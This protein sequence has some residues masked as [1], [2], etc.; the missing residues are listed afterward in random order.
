MTADPAS[1]DRARYWD[2]RYEQLGDERVS[3]HQARPDVSLELIDALGVGRSAGVIDVGG[4]SSRLVDELIARDFTDLTVMDVSPVALDIARRRLDHPASVNW[5]PTDILTWTPRRRW[6]L[7]HDR[8]VFHFLTA[9]ADRTAYLRR[10]VDA[11]T[12]TGKFII[13][14]FAND[15]PN[16]CSG[17]PVSRFNQQELADTIIGAIP[18]ATI[19]TTRN[20]VHATPSGTT[21]PFTWIAGT[22]A[23]PRRESS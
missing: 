3:W 7:W 13:G 12:P 10:L 18:G 2:D 15:G 20:E 14:T 9:P 5:L 4:G 6:N 11:L 16:H 22:T 17:L 1:H 23:R 21:Q 8:A 19:T